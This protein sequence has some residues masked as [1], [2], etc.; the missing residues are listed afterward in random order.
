MSQSK[1]F[2]KIK[3]IIVALIIVNDFFF[4]LTPIKLF[5]KKIVNIIK[6]R[7]RYH[8]C[9]WT[10]VLFIVHTA[11]AFVGS[12]SRTTANKQNRVFKILF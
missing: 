12:I 8:F 2:R 6:S 5:S 11:R 4:V 3:M 1:E 10:L 9:C 7:R